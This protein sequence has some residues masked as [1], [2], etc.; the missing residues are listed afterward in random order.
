MLSGIG[1]WEGDDFVLT[2]Q[3]GDSGKRV[4]TR[5]VWSDLKLD[6]FTQTIY[7]SASGDHL[8]KSLTIKAVR[9]KGVVDH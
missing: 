2:D 8:E 1:K 6:S 9:S 7:Q 3:H 5:E 4:F